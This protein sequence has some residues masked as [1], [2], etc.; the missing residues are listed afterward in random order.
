M[1]DAGNLEVP[2]FKNKFSVAADSVGKA[3]GCKPKVKTVEE[4]LG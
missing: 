2:D 4:K 1:S 3:T